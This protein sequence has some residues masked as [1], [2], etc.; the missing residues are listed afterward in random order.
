ML[1]VFIYELLYIAV[2]NIQR[3]DRHRIALR[4]RFIRRDLHM[5]IHDSSQSNQGAVDVLVFAENIVFLELII[6]GLRHHKEFLTDRGDNERSAVRV[7]DDKVAGSVELVISRK[8]IEH[9]ALAASDIILMYDTFEVV[10]ICDFFDDI[11][12]LLVSGNEFDITQTGI[13]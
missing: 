1:T 9:E 5:I 13:D 4:A 7:F 6:R 3:L 8:G 11:T 10:G 2:H 12:D